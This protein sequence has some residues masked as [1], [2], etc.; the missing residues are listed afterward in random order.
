MAPEYGF[1][2]NLTGIRNDTQADAMANH[3]AEVIAEATGKP[4]EIEYWPAS[5]EE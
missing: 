4:I 5:A 3:L 1:A 2:F